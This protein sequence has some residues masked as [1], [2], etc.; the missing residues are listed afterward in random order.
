[1]LSGGY[2][3]WLAS[4]PLGKYPLRFGPS[5]DPNRQDEPVAGAP[6]AE[7]RDGIPPE[8]AVRQAQAAVQRL[9]RANE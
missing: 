7:I 8:Q 2:V 1:M 5:Y 4:S 9:S 6:A 3:P